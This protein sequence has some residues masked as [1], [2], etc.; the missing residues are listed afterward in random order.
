MRQPDGENVLYKADESDVLI[1]KYFQAILYWT[2]MRM[3]ETSC[4]CC[5]I[6]VGMITSI[7]MMT[8]NNG[9]TGKI[10]LLAKGNTPGP[11]SLTADLYP[12]PCSPSP[13]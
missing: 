6:E 4:R 2:V 12:R 8:E 7:Q 9:P 5:P 1:E 11:D 3:L 13:H 10:E